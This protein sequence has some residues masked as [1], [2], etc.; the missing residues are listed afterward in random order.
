MCIRDRIL[1]IVRVVNEWITIDVDNLVASRQNDFI[2]M[3]SQTSDEIFFY[4]TYTDGQDL[5]LESWFKWKLLGPAQTV[6]VDQDDMFS[7]IKQGSQ[8]ILST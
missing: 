7:V 2:A 3:S 4:K 8:Y 6:Q 1:D 5:L